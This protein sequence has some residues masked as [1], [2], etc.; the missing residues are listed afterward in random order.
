MLTKNQIIEM[1][2]QFNQSARLEWLQLFDTTALRRYLD[3]LQWTMEPRGGQSTWIREGDTPAVVS[4]LP[5][6]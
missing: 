3:H 1:I 5:Q 4:R 2:Q 6:D